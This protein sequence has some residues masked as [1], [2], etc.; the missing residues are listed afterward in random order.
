MNAIVRIAGIII[1]VLMIC[2][3]I[4][5]IFAPRHIVELFTIAVVIHGAGLIIRYVTAKS[6]R[7]GWDLICGILQTVFGFVIIFST[8]EILT[9]DGES[10]IL[11]GGMILE[12]WVIR[13]FIAFWL[14]IMGFSNIFTAGDKEQHGGRKSGWT[15]VGGIVSIL[16]GIFCLALPIISTVLLVFT[17]G[18]IAGV[19]LIC[20][21]FS[22]LAAALT[23]KDALAASVEKV[24]EAVADNND[25]N[26]GPPAPA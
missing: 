13:L 18:I 25:D 11:P 1:S 23:G 14:L 24:A 2:V 21:G 6:K 3:G 20:M 7:N 9:A 15:I 12:A 5:L 4:S 16:A 17:T 8:T 19:A 10:L 26:P 22:G